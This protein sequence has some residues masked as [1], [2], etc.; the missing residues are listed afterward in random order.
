MDKHDRPYVCKNPECKS[1]Q[2]FTYSGGLSRHQREVHGLYGGAK[3]KLFCN[4]HACRRHSENPFTRRENLAEHERRVHK[5]NEGGILISPEREMP[6]SPVAGQDKQ[7]PLKESQ[8]RL[9]EN[10][11]PLN[12]TQAPTIL[13]QQTSFRP[14]NT[15]LP[16]ASPQRSSEKGKRKRSLP[17]SNES[18]GTSGKDMNE[19]GTLRTQI[20]R[21]QLENAELKARAAD[22]KRL[23]EI[24]QQDLQQETE[25]LRIAE[26]AAKQEAER[27][28]KDRD[29]L[30]RARA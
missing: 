27:M 7:I 11:V 30:V 25:A 2:G 15:P 1:L 4:Y 17:A 22:L 14:L 5:P 29:E 20:K 10:Q 18:R 6:D 8:T 26:K 23:H 24:H 16:S 28:R 13:R 12:G 19:V 21:L 3:L 9:E